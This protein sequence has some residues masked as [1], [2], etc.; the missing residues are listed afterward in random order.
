M[1]GMETTNMDQNE[2]FLSDR[3]VFSNFPNVT[4]INTYQVDTIQD[5]LCELG[6]KPRMQLKQII[7]FSLYHVIV[8]PTKMIKDLFKAST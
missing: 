8:R 3:M 1:Y 4:D 6:I 7:I 5:F 2:S